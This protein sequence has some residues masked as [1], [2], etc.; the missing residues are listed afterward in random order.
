MYSL[1]YELNSRFFQ[2]LQLKNTFYLP[3]KP[4]EQQLKRM[5]HG[6][7]ENGRFSDEPHD[8]TDTNLSWANAAQEVSSQ[9]HMIWPFG[10]C[11]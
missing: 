5:S 3:L 1:E 8:I 7:S 6:Y 9:I 4:N 2:P 11:H 10:L